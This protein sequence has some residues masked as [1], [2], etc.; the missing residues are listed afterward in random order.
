MAAISKQEHQVEPAV[1]TANAPSS[2]VKPQPR[3]VGDPTNT[4]M[5]ALLRVEAD[6]RGAADP[7]QLVHLIANETR[8]LVRARQV[9]VMKRSR[10]GIFQIE[11]ISSIDVVDRNTPLVRWI[12]RIIF[13]L[14]KDTG[15]NDLREFT[16]PAYCSDD[17]AEAATYPFRN[18]LW[19]PMALADGTVFAGLL[20]AREQVWLEADSVVVRRLTGCFAHAWSALAG[21]KRLGK[22][23]A[24]GK[25]IA[26]V[27][28]IGL[29]VT[30]ALPVPMTALAPAQIVPKDAFV[31]SAPID[32]T[33]REIAVQP[34]AQ[35]SA[36]D[37][38]L[39]F[40]DTRLRNELQLADSQ[41][42][43]AQSKLKRASLAAFDDKE[44]RR[45]LRV[46]M[47]EL[48]LRK[49][50][51]SYASDLLSKVNVAATQ[52][53]I[54]IFNSKKEWTGRPVKTG[55]RIMEIANPGKVEVRVD[56]PVGDALLLKSGAS[57]KIYMDADPLK[58]ITATVIHASH[59]ASEDE[60]GVLSYRLT[61]QLEGSN[62]PPR[63]GTRGTA[64][65]YGEDAA[66]FYYLFR[67]PV[68]AFRQRFG[69]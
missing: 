30:M 60:R 37:V 36:G 16:L 13:R 69:L 57:V 26:P 50:E 42:A 31:V 49:T 15:L 6:A 65:V 27:V 52:T 12:E 24:R 14:N 34:N 22:I 17:D 10:T 45:E 63:I 68:R 38:L 51:R 41:V 61:A 33:V 5:L 7:K 29:F 67:R 25:F 3:A 35:V 1:G 8:K 19:V 21:P 64:Q 46:A 48:E 2:N 43:V 28:A 32:G 59:E 23:G 53:G 9:F 20:V 54:A 58:P 11:A 56:L 39:R 47:S 55:E 18:L 40:E 66:L 44:S 62:S 4:A